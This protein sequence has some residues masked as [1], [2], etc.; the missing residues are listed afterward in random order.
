M[1]I[2]RFVF[3]SI[4]LFLLLKPIFKTTN[5]VIQK[6]IIVFAQD[7]SR[8][9]LLNK[10]S[11]YYRTGY[12]NNITDVIEELRKDHDVR[13]I[14][15]SDITYEDSIMD[16]SG[17]LTDISSVFTEVAAR[18]SGMNLG[19]VILATDGIYNHGN[20]PVYTKNI[21]FPI[22]SIALGDTIA[23]KDLILKDLMH[24]RVAFY[25][26]TFPLRV[27]IGTERTSEKESEIIISRDGKVV[28]SSK[29]ELPENSTVKTLEIELP[30]NQL[31]IQ[32]YQI[33]L[34]PLSEEI[35]YENNSATFII[36]VIDNRN[37]ILL[38]ANAPHPDIGAINYALKDNPDFE[39]TTQYIYEFNANIKDFDLI[40][41]HQLPSLNNNPS[42]IFSE[43]EKNAVSTLYILGLSSSLNA[44]NNL[45]TGF[46]IISRSNN[47]D[48]ATPI[49]NQG[50]VSFNT[51]VD[52]NFFRQL[53]PLKVFFG[54]YNFMNDPKILLYQSI[55]GVKTEK[56]LVAFTEN[57]SVKNGIIAGDGLWKWRIDDFKINSD[58]TNFN[59]LIN[60]MIQYLI[61]KNIQDQLIIENKQI[62]NENEPVILNGEFYNNAF[63]TVPN[64]NI[65]LLLEDPEGKEFKY[66]FG[67]FGN[68]YR[69]NLGRM[70]AGFYK[71]TAITKFDDKDY[72]VSGNLIVQKINIESLSTT[73][74]HG[75]LYK[76]AEN[77]GGQVFNI[78]EISQLNE[79][80]SKNS[81]ITNIA[82][83]KEKLY[84]ITDLYFLFFI[85]LLFASCEW[86]LR[87][88]FGGY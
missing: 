69:L 81:N 72:S 10:D 41:L 1:T 85:I 64:L 76:L 24:N 11:S 58:H 30:A 70:N 83:S 25:G 61:V 48:D 8:S 4:I 47:S 43:I 87:K 68:G 12:K 20:N 84:T 79:V 7:N 46:E 21:N 38:L 19:A 42:N 62:F 80:I 22:Y 44:F 71:Y 23:Q 78:S 28:Y 77:S 52:P 60:R 35:S 59:S 2:L 15:F 56:P 54:D 3:V 74:N 40:I 66:T 26:N 9:I 53:S 32:Q 86:V 31:G 82:Y 34:K 45:D 6:P 63:E 57:K 73:A 50:F 29:F 75:I 65:E 27:F 67:N 88:Y 16:F 13:Y 49:F 55:N 37:K 5:T 39:L 51:D 33:L 14:Q 36:N 18:Y 17:E